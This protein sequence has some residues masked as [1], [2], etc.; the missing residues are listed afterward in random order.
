MD[1]KIKQ[2][3]ISK[4]L[5]QNELAEKLFVTRQAVSKWELG[6]AVPDLDTLKK[7]SEIFECDLEDLMQL[8]NVTYAINDNIVKLNKVNRLQKIIIMIMSAIMVVLLTLSITLPMVIFHE[9]YPKIESEGG[10][11]LGVIGFYLEVNGDGKMSNEEIGDKRDNNAFLFFN[12]SLYKYVWQSHNIETF[13][14]KTDGKENV[15]FSAGNK[16]VEVYCSFTFTVKENELPLIEIW[17]L[18]DMKNGQFRPVKYAT[19]FLRDTID[20]GSRII[21]DRKRDK[22][23]AYFYIKIIKLTEQTNTPE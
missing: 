21:D 4:G 15:S 19:F 23:G 13:A 20:Q 6:K 16:L 22:G 10:D 3:R 9:M 8:D 12:P 11:P 1:N 17:G 14:V 5:S 18:V 7:L 2:Y